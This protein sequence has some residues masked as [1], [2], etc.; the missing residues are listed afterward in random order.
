MLQKGGSLFAS[1]AFRKILSIGFEFESHDLAKLS[2][3]R[4]RKA[5]I[6]SDLALRN[7]DEKMAED[8]IRVFGNNYLTIHVPKTKNGKS[9]KREPKTPEQAPEEKEDK[10]HETGENDAEELGDEDANEDEID[11]EL[12]AFLEYMEEQEKEDEFKEKEKD[13]YLEYF[14]ESREKDT[15]YD[16]ENT[17][18]QLTNDNGEIYFNTLLDKKC[19]ALVEKGIQKNDMYLFKTRKGRIYR[20]HFTD[21]SSEHC[22]SFSGLE[23]VI[24]YYKSKIERQYVVK[25][26]NPNIILDTFVD[27]ISRIVDHFANLKKMRGT[28]LIADDRIHYSPLG[29]YDNRRELYYKPGTNLFYMATYD[30]EDLKK[31]KNLAA[32]TFAPQMTFRCNACDA[33]EIMKEILKSDP[34][35]KL[36]TKLIREHKSELQTF[37]LVEKIVDELIQR[38]NID[39]PDHLIHQNSSNDKSFRTYIFFI[40]YK[41]YSYIQGH[42][43]ILKENFEQGED[44][45]YLKDYLS[46]ASRHSNSVLYERVKELASELY[47]IEEPQEIKDL[48]FDEKICDA[49]FDLSEMNENDY[50]DDGNFKYGDPTHSHLVKDDPH[51]GDPMYSLS[52]YFDHFETADENEENDWF[53]VAKIDIFSTTFDLTDDKILLENRYFANEFILFAKNTL[54]SKYKGNSFS[55]N[56]MIKMVNKYYEP[57]KIQKMINVEYNPIKK[58]IVKRCKPGFVRSNM[59]KC[60]VPGLKLKPKKSRRKS[61]SR[62][63]RKSKRS[64]RSNGSNNS[65]GRHNSKTRKIKRRR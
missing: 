55:L 44:K 34:S 39:Y 14:F 48:L 19:K 26:E 21:N 56:D 40:F 11:E 37:N 9:E 45:T 20:I 1:A 49:L 52:S 65:I 15:P 63:T 10:Q 38:H 31:E 64:N 13:S 47:G 30:E 41:I 27:A 8:D 28:F 54:S 23:V 36:G 58:K 32:M 50:D 25:S 29:H 18:F 59:F 33:L 42:V 61:I 62:K 16:R 51:Y 22:N 12:A 43:A 24:T 57:S 53:I 4:D 35:F 6:N 17:K 3:S 46:F 7:V 2:L 5:L 60:M